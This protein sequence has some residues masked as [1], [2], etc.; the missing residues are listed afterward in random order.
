MRLQSDGYTVV[1]DRWQAITDINGTTHIRVDFQ[2][3]RP[4]I[5]QPELRAPTPDQIA[6]FRTRHQDALAQAEYKTGRD[7]RNYIVASPL[8]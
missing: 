1:Y 8:D 5:M 3:N 4:L 7:G 6:H 2:A